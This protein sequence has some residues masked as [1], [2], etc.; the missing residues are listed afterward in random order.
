MRFGERLL[1]P[2]RGS[3]GRLRRNEDE[4]GYP[5]R[6]GGSQRS[7]RERDIRACELLGRGRARETRRMHHDARAAQELLEL[8]AFIVPASDWSN[9]E[10]GGRE[11]R[12]Q[13]TPNET[14]G[15]RD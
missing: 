13:V 14:V 3:R 4:P 1:E 12:A 2:W 6:L 8:P 11:A 15:A 9:A 7:L 10:P 5:R